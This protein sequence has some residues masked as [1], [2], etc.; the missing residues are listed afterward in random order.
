MRRLLTGYAVSFNRRC[1]RYGH[2]FQNRYK[3]IL[4]QEDAYLGELVRYIHLSNILK[5]YLPKFNGGTMTG[6]MSGLKLC[7]YAVVFTAAIVIS[8]FEGHARAD[9]CHIVVD[10]YKTELKAVM[11]KNKEFTATLKRV[12][13]DMKKSAKKYKV[14]YKDVNSAAKDSKITDKEKKKIFKMA[15]K[16]G[17]LKNSA[18]EIKFDADEL[19]R[20]IE[21]VEDIEKK[22]MKVCR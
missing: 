17:T 16:T 10:Q 1:R 14:A 19:E 3:S 4:C 9:D 2:L 22:M 5:K 8:M 12:L 6:E 13:K 7:Q 11:L 21:F 18:A 20:A 15:K